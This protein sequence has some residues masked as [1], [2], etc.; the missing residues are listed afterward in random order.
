M[1]NARSLNRDYEHVEQ[2]YKLSSKVKIVIQRH[3]MRNN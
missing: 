1:T 3:C 2:A